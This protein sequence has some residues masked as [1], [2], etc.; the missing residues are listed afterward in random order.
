MASGPIFPHSSFPTTSDAFP[1]FHVAGNSH[2]E[3]LGVSA[4]L[5]VNTIWRLR[6]QMPTTIPSGTMKLLLRALSAPGAT[7]AAK[8]NPKWAIVD[9]Q[10]SP[11]VTL[12]A[13]GVT[14]V[15]WTGSGNEDNEYLD[16]KINLD[17]HAY[18]PSSNAELVMDLVF[19]ND[20][21]TLATVSTWIVSIIWE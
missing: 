13:E 7:Q 6:F 14:T 4:S 9:T 3:G 21:W 19:E 1:N 5:S 17:A 8:V 18:S 11:N 2:D 20:G 15:D 10:E 16:T 12:D